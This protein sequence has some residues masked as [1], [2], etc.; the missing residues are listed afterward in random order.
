MAFRFR[1]TITLLPGV[2]INLSKSGISTTVGPRG[3]SVNLKPGR[4]TRTTVGVPGT[5]VS[6]SFTHRDSPEQ[7][8]PTFGGGAQI[9]VLLLVAAL[10]WL[11]LFR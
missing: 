10:A 11:V 4:P 5:G 2:R 3:L 9:V 1:K 8:E 6:Q 7:T